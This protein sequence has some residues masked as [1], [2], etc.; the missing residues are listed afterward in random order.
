[1]PISAVTVRRIENTIKKDGEAMLTDV[2][3]QKCQG[4]R[5]RRRPASITIGEVN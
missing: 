2:N 5:V 1:M 4:C 3:P